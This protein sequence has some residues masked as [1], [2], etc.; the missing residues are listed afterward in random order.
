RQIRPQP[1]RNYFTKVAYRAGLF[2]GP[3]YIKVYIKLPQFGVSFGAGLPIT[4]YNRLSPNQ[5]T[6]VNLSF[7][8]SRRGN[9]NNILKEDLFRISVGFNFSD[10]W[11]R[12]P[13]YD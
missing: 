9:N 6:I 8:Y 7:E 11:F 4:N 12:K 13:R 3:D 1:A 2:V 10:V 5:F